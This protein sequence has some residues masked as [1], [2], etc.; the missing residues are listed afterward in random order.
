MLIGRRKDSTVLSCYSNPTI[1]HEA[2]QMAISLV[3][4]SFSCPRASARLI[5]RPPAYAGHTCPNDPILPAAPSLEPP[6]F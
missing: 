4:A 5:E 2:A 1:K 3:S 6:T